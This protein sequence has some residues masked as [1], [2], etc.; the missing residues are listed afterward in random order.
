MCGDLC[1][2]M[3]ETVFSAAGVSSVF[4]QGVTEMLVFLGICYHD[5]WGRGLDFIS[6]LQPS[7]SSRQLLARAELG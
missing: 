6:D 1:G 5:C 3:V 7:G 4:Y 2:V